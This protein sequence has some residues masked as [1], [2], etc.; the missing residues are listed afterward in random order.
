MIEI[1]EL[2]LPILHKG[3]EELYAQRKQLNAVRCGRRWGKTKF[4]ERLAGDGVM[5][6]KK[7]GVF[8]PEN[9]QL[10]EPWEH[11][12]DALNPMLKSFNRNEGRMTAK[13]GGICDFWIL[14]DN[15]LA[16]RGREYDL[17]LIDEAAFTKTPQM[18][19]IWH[20]GIKPTMLT[21]RGK[22]WIFSTPNGADSDNFFYKICNDPEMGFSTFH[23]PTI[24]NPYVP[25]DELEKERQRNHPMV[26]RQEYLA[27]FVDWSGEAFFPI[28]KL[29]IDGRPMPMPDVV[30]G[31]FAVIDTAVKGGLEHD[32]T[33][34]IYCGVNKFYGQPLIILDYD[35]IQI[36]G[37]ML[38]NWMP[39]VFARLE[40]LA[41]MTK[42]RTG[43]QIG[44]HIED[45]AAGAILLQQGR[46]RGWNTHAIDSTLTSQGKDVRAL[47]VSGY[48]HQ[49]KIKITE[50][51]YDKT[52][53]FKGSNRNHLLTQIANFRMGDKDAYK[54]PDDLLD[55]F[56][57]SLAIGVG[58]K[59]GY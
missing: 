46:I 53:T 23:A 20:M 4:L 9:K 8:A 15:E 35:I 11:I 5:K 32:G 18:I 48:Y 50:Y 42:S 25:A 43:T 44:V 36:D 21:T 52:V 39:S 19:D 55:A 1:V 28:D 38:E 14:N 31:V 56:V 54:R 24:N 45:A 58:D 49:E 6:G 40:E 2:N 26:F 59:Y 34:I 47:D 16:G 3:Q 41:A 12:R 51:A 10:Q 29:L 22:A 13:N 37:A 27:E 30:D 33:A 17:V 57:Y 7:V